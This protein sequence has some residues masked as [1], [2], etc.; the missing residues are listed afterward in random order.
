MK[1]P[2][3]IYQFNGWN[4]D[5]ANL[6][7][8]SKF[9]D[10]IVVRKYWSSFY[11]S[12][13]SLNFDYFRRVLAFAE[14]SKLDVKVIIAPGVRSPEWI[15]ENSECIKLQISNGE[16]KGS[17][18]AHPIPWDENY[19]NA[20]FDFLRA[21][22]NEFANHP[23]LTY[24]AVTGPNGHNGEVAL[25]R[26]SKDNLYWKQYINNDIRA[27]RLNLEYAYYT[28]LVKFKELFSKK[29]YY[30]LALINLSLP[31]KESGME[32]E[33]KK[34][35]IAM[36]KYIDPISFGIQT[37]GLNGENELSH[38]ELIKA[39][40]GFTAFQSRVKSNLFK[41][42]TPSVEITDI[43]IENVNQHYE[44]RDD[45]QE[46]E[47]INSLEIPNISFETEAVTKRDYKKKILKNMIKVVQY[48]EVE[49]VELPYKLLS[50]LAL[51]KELR[52]LRDLL[53]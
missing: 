20:W 40:K 49:S 2:K 9:I 52:E 32:G 33:Y 30:T 29:L 34:N 50:D 38:W 45:I 16:G 23:N 15:K 12:D 3:G 27:L 18:A 7:F 13:R 21:F 51:K 11:N 14:S 19:L 35:L 46:N 44:I 4:D 8:S 25:P 5:F 37:N 39:F 36:G 48:Y 41:G 42:Y 22:A 28:T 53:S 24:M 1:K 26:T 6:D 31:I 47:G 43:S 10:G 17:L